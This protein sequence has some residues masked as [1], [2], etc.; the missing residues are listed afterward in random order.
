MM[1]KKAKKKKI[2]M[3]T[4]YDTPSAIHVDKAL[5]DILLVGDS[6]GMVELGYETTLPVTME[7][8]IHHCQ[9]V[10]R[11]CKRPLIVADMPFGSFEACEKDAVRNA[12]R[13]LKEGGGVDAV[14]IEG[15][16]VR[17]GT[18]KR[19]VES[20]VAVMG[21]IGLT[22][23]SFSALGG[24]RAQGRSTKEALKL[25]E[26]ALAL[27]KAGCFG[28]VIECVPAVVAK[29]ITEAVSIPTIGIGAGPY[30]DGQ[31]LVYHDMLGMMQHHHHAQFTPSFCKQYATV[32]YAIQNGLADYKHDV[33]NELFPTKDFSPYK[34]SKQDEDEFIKEFNN[35]YSAK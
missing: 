13:I 21:H 18:I 9:A 7:D 34:I 35:L 27:E 32:G 11:G 8:I 30:T 33:E 2:T 20:G 26:D 4:A 12:A 22:P 15:G 19:V 16:A 28:M 5:I 14:K 3:V 25:V 24:F 6:V 17:A 10:T 31:V 29:A 23:Q 1:N